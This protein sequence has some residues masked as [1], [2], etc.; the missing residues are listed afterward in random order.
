MRPQKHIAR[1]RLQHAGLG[2][3]FQDG[4]RCRGDRGFDGPD[5]GQLAGVPVG[6]SIIYPDRELAINPGRVFGSIQGI[7]TKD[8]AFG[9]DAVFGSA[10]SIGA[11]SNAP[12][13]RTRMAMLTA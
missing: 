12:I 1:Q 9:M 13:S 8:P 2:P 6:E 3:G 5:V 10:R 7:A 11:I 4:M